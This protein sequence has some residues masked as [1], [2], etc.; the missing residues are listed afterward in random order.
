[1]SD[2][3]DGAG[4][5]SGKL[6]GQADAFGRLVRVEEQNSSGT[7]AE[8]ARY[9]YD[10]MGHMTTV[11]MGAQNVPPQPA[12]PGFESGTSGWLAWGNP[13][14]SVGAPSVG[15]SNSLQLTG[16]VGHGMYQVLGGVTPGQTYVVSAWVQV[17][18]YATAALLVNDANSQN[19]ASGYVQNTFGMWQ[20]VSV[21]YTATS[22][23]HLAIL[24]QFGAGSGRLG[25][26]FQAPG[27]GSFPGPPRRDNA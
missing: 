24:L 16:P 21:S 20:R 23:A 7:L 5:A 4:E 12:D 17:A 25:R 15:G 8:T 13:N 19:F 22:T 27:S 3:R 26:Q 18:G 1:V 14:V 10:V 11:Q 2:V 9:N 6:G